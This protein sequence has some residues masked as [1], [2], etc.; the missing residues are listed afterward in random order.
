MFGMNGRGSFHQ[1]IVALIAFAVRKSGRAG[2]ADV[3]LQVFQLVAYPANDAVML[4]TV[5]LAKL[6]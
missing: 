5:V 2:V 4:S 1:R 6:D 3:P